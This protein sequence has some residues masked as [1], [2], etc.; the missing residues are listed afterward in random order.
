METVR[1]LNLEPGAEQTFD[2]RLKPG[3]VAE[4]AYTLHFAAVGE[5][6]LQTRLEWLGAGLSETPV[7]MAANTGWGTAEIN[8]LTDRNVKVDAKLDRAVHVFLPE[9]TSA[10]KMDERAELPASALTPGPARTHLLRQRFALDFKEP[11]TAHVLPAQDYDLSDA[12]SGE[13]LTLVHES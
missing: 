6:S 13:R 9:S 8:P 1:T 2:L 11:L 7:V 12:D 3:S 5:A 4:V 10:L